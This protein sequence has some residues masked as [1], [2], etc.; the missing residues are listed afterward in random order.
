MFKI[1]LPSTNFSE[2]DVKVSSNGKMY[3]VFLDTIENS[4]YIY[5]KSKNQFFEKQYEGSE[6]VYLKE[7]D[8]HFFVITKKSNMLIMHKIN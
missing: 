8:N 3:I 4:I 7:I 5:D 2:I 1:D 6:F